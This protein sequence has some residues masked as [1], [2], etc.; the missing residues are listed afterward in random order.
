MTILPKRTRTILGTTTKMMMMTMMT[1]I[2]NLLKIS[3]AHAQ[4]SVPL[5]ANLASST[6]LQAATFI[7]DWSTWIT[8]IA[9]VVLVAVIIEVLV[10]ALRK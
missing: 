2:I 3:V 8:L 6:G 5:P 7:S 1:N 10:G 4:V 9:G